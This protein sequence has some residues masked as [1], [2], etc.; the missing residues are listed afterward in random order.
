MEYQREQEGNMKGH[1]KSND[2]WQKR[3]HKV[4]SAW[5]AGLAMLLLTA[6]AQAIDDPI[7]YI[8]AAADNSKKGGKIGAQYDPTVNYPGSYDAAQLYRKN[9]STGAWKA[10]SHPTH[11]KDV[12]CFE[13]KAQLGERGI[14][15]GNFNQNGS[16]EGR[17]EA[18]DWATGNFLNFQFQGDVNTNTTGTEEE[19]E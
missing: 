4:A 12:N 7:S 3:H 2:Q 8:L 1:Y 9:L 16:C 19:M 17:G 6:P 5:L 14:W 18:S 11:L 10:R 13:A 15:T